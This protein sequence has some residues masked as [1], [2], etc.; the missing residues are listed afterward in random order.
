MTTPRVVVVG[1]GIGGLAAALSLA[2]RRIPVTLVERHAAAGGRVRRV[3]VA[4]R[5]FDAGPTVLTMHWVFEALFARAG[6]RFDEH[7]TL[8]RA[9]LLARHS[10]V[11][12]EPLDLFADL[13]RSI[14]AIEALAGAGEAA[15]YRRFAARTEA[16]FDTLDA[17]FMRTQRPNLLSLSL[18][19]G[20]RGMIDLARIEPFTTL[21]RSLA[22][23]FADPRLRQLFARYATYCGSSPFRAPATLML[24]AH[25]E[26]A[27]V[28]LVEGGLHA[29]ALALVAAIRELGVEC[30]FGTGA[31]HIDTR[32]RR[33][34]G[35]TLESGERLD[36]D[37]VIFNGDTAALSRGLLGARLRRAATPRHEPSLSAV[38][39]C[40]VAR[41]SGF[42]LAHH[43]VFFGGDYADEF[44]SVFDLGTV[45]ADPTVYVCA[46]DRAG[47]ADTAAES[48]APERLFSL[49]NAPARVLDTS[50]IAAAARHMDDALARHG[51]RF[52]DERGSALASPREFAA[53]FP[54]TDGALYGRP[55]HGWTSSFRRPGARSRVGGLYLAGGGVHPGPGVPMTALSGQLAADALCADL[56]LA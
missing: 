51:L 53:L 33:V 47:G 29:L 12:S 5:G 26:R 21:W 32:A 56:R 22:R 34:R 8:R 31:A 10:W 37:A 55:T 41:A 1:A 16:V 19:G 54:A 4:G 42:A 50:E 24:V 15:A 27:G 9:E 43:T 18:G 20:L 46:Q 44:D 6:L 13:E 39:R 7:V 48:E 17:R 23:S 28:W 49:I 38:T 45:T 35:V 3:E 11:G 40:R 14:A 52:G 36:A 25:V 30:R 2:A